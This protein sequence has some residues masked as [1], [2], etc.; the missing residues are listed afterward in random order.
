MPSYWLC[1]NVSNR[2]SKF[3]TQVSMTP[4]FCF[5]TSS[6]LVTVFSSFSMPS[7]HCL[8][9][10]AISACC[11]SIWSRV[12]LAVAA[13]AW[14]A[15]SDRKRSRRGGSIGVRFSIVGRI[16]YRALTLASCSEVSTGEDPAC[17]PSSSR[18]ALAFSRDSFSLSC[19]E[20]SART[21][22]LMVSRLAVDACDRAETCFSRESR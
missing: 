16:A 17:L 2:C 15:L 20:A 3:F 4:A 10:V 9:S 8:I 21:R 18:R 13:S 11:F 7:F 12:W 14:M 6:L 1:V 22:R 5:M 19:S